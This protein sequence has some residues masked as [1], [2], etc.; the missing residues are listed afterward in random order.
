MWSQYVLNLRNAKY[1]RWR[2]SRLDEMEVRV[3]FS[4]LNIMSIICY[5]IL[6]MHIPDERHQGGQGM[7]G[8]W[9]LLRL[10]IFPLE[11]TRF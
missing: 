1:S 10:Q 7:E 5:G 8:S 2:R 11:S 6:Q 4:A 9:I 3:V